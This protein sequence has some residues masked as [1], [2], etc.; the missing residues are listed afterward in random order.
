M[1]PLV[2]VVQAQRCAQ[3]APNWVVGRWGRGRAARV[4]LFLPDLARNLG[5]NRRAGPGA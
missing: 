3:L 2:A 4:G 5:A 1:V